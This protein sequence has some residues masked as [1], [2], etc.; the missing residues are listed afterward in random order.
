[1][2]EMATMSDLHTSQ[3]LTLPCGLTLPNRL[4]KAAL[5]ESMTKRGKP[6]GSQFRTVYGEWAKGGWGLILTG[7]DPYRSSDLSK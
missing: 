3:P 5:A 7:S 4:A 1:M 6:P 2:A